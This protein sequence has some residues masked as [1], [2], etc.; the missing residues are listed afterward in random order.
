VKN[1]ILCSKCRKRFAVPG[2][3]QP[4]RC[5][6][7]GQAQFI[8]TADEEQEPSVEE[9]VGQPSQGGDPGNSSL[10][11]PKTL[12]WATPQGRTNL[13]GSAY[14][15]YLDTVAQAR[16]N[17][18]DNAGVIWDWF[19]NGPG[20]SAVEIITAFGLVLLG[21]AFIANQQQTYGRL[22]LLAVL[23][24]FAVT[25]YAWMVLAAYLGSLE[26]SLHQF[27]WRVCSAI[28]A[29][30]FLV[31][32][33]VVVL[34][35]LLVL[36]V[37]LVLLGLWTLPLVLVFVPMRLSHAV[38]LL[39]RRITWRCPYDDCG[40]SGL[41]IHVCSCGN[42]YDDLQPS[43]YGIFYHTCRHGAESQQLPTL[44]M[45]GRNRLPRLCRHCRRPLHLS[46]LG[47]LPELPI[48]LVGA[49]GSGKTVFLCQATRL[50]LDHLGKLPRSRVQIDSSRDAQE[51]AKNEQALARGRLPPKT[52]G[53]VMEALG[54]AV[55]LEQPKRLHS[56]LY[57]YDAPGEHFAT[58][59]RFGRKQHIRHLGGILLLVDPL[60]LPLL[61]QRARRLG[62]PD[63]GMGTPLNH[64]VG[65]L[66]T[67]IHQALQLPPAARCKVPLAV[68]LGKADLLP[69]SEYPILAGLCPRPGSAAPPDLS[70]RCRAALEKLGA[71]NSVRAL[72]QK[73]ERIAYFACTS[74]GRAPDPRDTRPFRPAG[75]IEPLLWLLGLN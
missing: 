28:A 6:A 20:A 19:V 11:V 64:L 9:I 53:D 45:L 22:T 27:I 40:R 1:D 41:P 47:E 75:V 33:T 50:L 68:V 8:P 5:P 49:A 13:F 65:V 15:R 58:M 7:C 32:A 72:E 52:S 73:F 63:L 66:I 43:F 42:R 60:A 59:D 44:D 61:R 36:A 31:L 25:A 55:R 21:I 57:L 30:I 26:L 38:W 37:Y 23:A 69:V 48:A 2:D 51:Q 67:G 29:G 71:G 62:T 12:P 54:V 46:S 24:L 56:L 74:L 17:L 39:W 70:A 4:L 10:S 3:S 18:W 35:V 14:R 16:H 34:L